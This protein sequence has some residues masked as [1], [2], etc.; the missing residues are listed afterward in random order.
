MKAKMKNLD[1]Y[2]G[3]CGG[4]LYLH[5]D[6]FVKCY[7]SKC[8]E[9]FVNYRWPTIELLPE[10]LVIKEEIKEESAII[11]EEKPKEKKSVK[12]GNKGAKAT[13]TKE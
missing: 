12:A 9:Y 10:K 2:C 11:K 7:N 4:K 3:E 6:D 8:K 5:K 1:L 13:K